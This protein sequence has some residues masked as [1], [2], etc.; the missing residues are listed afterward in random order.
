MMSTVVDDTFFVL[1]QAAMRALSTATMHCFVSTLS[2]TVAQLSGTFRDA[3]ARSLPPCPA[4]AIRLFADGAVPSAAAMEEAL[5]PLN[6]VV[7][8]AAYVS[9]MHAALEPQ[10]AQRCACLPA[11]LLVR[12]PAFLP[13]LP[14]CPS[15]LCCSCVRLLLLLLLSA[16]VKAF[17]HLQTV[18]NCAHVA[19]GSRWRR[20]RR[21]RAAASTTCSKRGL[22]CAK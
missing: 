3:L 19:T 2:L 13:V 11:C 18:A 15:T 12:L 1:R 6:N 4:A 5:A 9:K 10:A 8:C 14:L 22:R 21:Q 7:A 20:R 17:N 16:P